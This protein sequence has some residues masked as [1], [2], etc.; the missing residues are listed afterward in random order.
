MIPLIVVGCLLPSLYSAYTDA[1][2]RMLYDYVT[3]PVFLAGLVYSI[4]TGAWTNTV[5]TAFV[6]FA[7]FFFLAYKGGI[8]GGDAKFATAMAVWFGYPFIVAVIALGAILAF[9]YGSVELIQKKQ[10]ANR[11]I[12]Y[13]RGGVI[14]AVYGVDVMPEVKLPDDGEKVAGVV[15]FGTFIVIAAWIVYLLNQYQL[16]GGVLI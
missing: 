12:P 5:P 11:I 1:T 7:V 2:R 9:L 3:I 4:A 10:F 14:K 6:V 15:P 13:I 8:A 16:L